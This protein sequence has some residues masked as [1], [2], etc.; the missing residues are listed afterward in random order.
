MEDAIAHSMNTLD[1]VSAFATGA[2]VAFVL[3]V[4]ILAFVGASG[5]EIMRQG[6]RHRATSR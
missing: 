3:L 5:A 6:R 4:G 1:A 2:P